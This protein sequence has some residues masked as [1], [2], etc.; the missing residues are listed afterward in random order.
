MAGLIPFDGY[1]APGAR[2]V[3]IENLG[4]LIGPANYQAGGYNIN[5]PSLGMS[6]IERA[7]GSSFTQSGN[8]IAKFF[9]PAI[10]SSNEN[11]APTFPYVTVKWYYAANSVEVANNTNLGAE[12]SQYEFTGI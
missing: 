12:V 7:A 8:Y 1:P 4:D 2:A 3:K 9:Y 5:A 10:S 6:R 11:R